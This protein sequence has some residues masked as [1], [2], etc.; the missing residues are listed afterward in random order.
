MPFEHRHASSSFAS[1]NANLRSKIEELQEMNE[2][3]TVLIKKKEEEVYDNRE[4]AKELERDLEQKNEWNLIVQTKLVE[5]E[6]RASVLRAECDRLRKSNDRQIKELDLLQRQKE[7]LLH[8]NVKEKEEIFEKQTKLMN[9]NSIVDELV[10]RLFSYSFNTDSENDR[11]KKTLKEERIELLGHKLAFELE[12]KQNATLVK[13]IEHY[14]AKCKEKI[15]EC[16][17]FQSSTRSTLSSEKKLLSQQTK[18]LRRLIDA[19]SSLENSK[20]SEILRLRNRRKA[21]ELECDQLA[22]KL[23]SA[24]ASFRK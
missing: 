20:D 15:S 3:K 24:E 23:E 1:T 19:L 14:I 8:E 12:K 9:E 6:A 4:R 13:E 10:N 7:E 21:L 22:Q 17:N 16:E 5:S 18:E 2:E 11:K